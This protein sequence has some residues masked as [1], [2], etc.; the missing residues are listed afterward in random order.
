MVG[1][2]LLSHVATWPLTHFLALAEV[3]KTIQYQGR[4]TELDGSSLTGPHQLTVR[5][6]DSETGGVK[7][8][9]EQHSLLLKKDDRGIFSV[10]LGSHVPFEGSIT[11][12]TPLWLTIHVDGGEEFLPRQFLSAVSYAI[13]A[14][15]LDGLDSTQLV[16]LDST[17]ALAVM[18]GANLIN[19]NAANLTSGTIPDERFPS[20]VSFLG[21]SIGP[22]EIEDGAV[23]SIK[24]STNSVGAA[25]LAP[26]A[27]QVGDIGV[28]DLPSHASTHQ[29]GGADPLHTVSAI[30]VGSTNSSGSSTSLARSDH[31]HEGVHT[32]NAGGPPLVGNVS[33]SGGAN[34]SLETTGQTIT[35]T[36]STGEAGNKVTNAASSA[37]TISSSTDTT[38]ATAT[39][40]KSQGS[41]ILLVIATVQLNH[42][43]TPS[44]KTV[45]VK[46]FRDTTQLDATYTARI[47]TA[48]ET[49]R[50]LPVT[51]H[52]WD[53][54]GSGTYT[55][56]LKARASG[57]G[58]QATIRRLSVIEIL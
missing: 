35:I 47:G 41:S 43:A 5:L 58:V 25:A 14:D 6:Y 15:Q 42:A 2:L 12:N 57:S 1:Y 18:S 39:I 32:I 8:W 48:N 31:Q 3:P 44:S 53:S 40:T 27:I 7:L 17:G 16:S 50:D 23:T 45:D 37:L 24:L 28:S 4:L 49:I 54:P 52:T 55:L 34:V 19:L 38:L 56:T 21:S 46:L 26:D 51:L 20:N 10:L 33:L 30:S 9:E 11:F 29:P 36:A 22:T 13:N